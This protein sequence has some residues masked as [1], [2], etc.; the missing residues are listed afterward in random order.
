FPEAAALGK[1]VVGR[2]LD[3]HPQPGN[4]PLYRS[5][6]VPEE[7]IPAGDLRRHLSRHLHE[8]HRL[9]RRVL[10]PEEIDAA[11][12]TL[13]HGGHVDFGNLTETLQR[14]I[15][16]RLRDDP[17][18]RPVI[19][20]K[21]ADEWLR[22]ALGQPPASY[23]GEGIP[24]EA[25][26]DELI[27]C[28]GSLAGRPD[29]PMGNLAPESVLDAYLSPE[30]FHFLR[31]CPT[32]IRAVI[33]DI[34]GTLLIS[35]PGAVKADPAFD[36]VLR[37]ILS[38][39]GHDLGASP[40]SVLHAA[41]RHH[42]AESGH[43]HP[44][45]DLLRIWQEVLGTA[46][47]LTDLVTKIEKAWHPCQ[48]MPRARETLLR[49]S[50]E[51]VMLGVLSNAQ[52]NTLPTLDGILGPVTPLLAPELTTLSYHHGIAKPSPELFRMLARRL[53]DHGIS[54]AETLF[55]GNDPRQDILPAQEAGFRTALFAGHPG[56]VRPGVC[57]PDLTLR[58]LSEIP[59]ATSS[60]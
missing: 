59:S 12:G 13:R 32:R 10:Q 48:P 35:P 50:G 15:L 5:I 22:E 49:L 44:E 38:A 16:M 21:P 40:T 11:M 31:T 1:P 18:L 29:E 9:Y 26:G 52:A 27:S 33:F 34:Y 47:D 37:D 2:E 4:H 25:Y 6:L 46:E 36:P 39:S 8:T 20:G 58:S 7:W 19:G 28:Y 55:V 24:E 23:T 60:F 14:G 51:G 17:S 45:I 30:N 56:S 41:V 43:A 53:E 3:I 54:P 57:T 42:H